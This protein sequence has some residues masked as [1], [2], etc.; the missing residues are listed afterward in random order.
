[1]AVRT[2]LTGFVDTRG[3]VKN[4]NCPGDMHHLKSTML[5]RPLSTPGQLHTSALH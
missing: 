2:A 4:D 5:L 1:M 3:V